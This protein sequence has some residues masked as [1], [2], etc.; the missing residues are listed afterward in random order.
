MKA[1]E[2]QGLRRLTVAGRHPVDG[3]TLADPLPMSASSRRAMR[4]LVRVL[5]PPSP[6]LPDLEDRI[7]DHVRRMLRYMPWSVSFGF[8]LS[9][10]LLDWSP[11]WRGVGFTRLQFLERARAEKLLT[12]LGES[13]SP[14]VRTLILGARGLILSTY[15]DQDEVHAALDYAPLAFF[16]NRVELRQRLLRG[17]AATRGDLIGLG[18]PMGA[19]GDELPSAAGAEP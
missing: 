1:R 17:E 12:D 9:L 19:R 10:H 2:K 3:F 16:E 15:F 11:L 5:C 14:L 6:V 8:V 7:E 18:R 13:S 4:G